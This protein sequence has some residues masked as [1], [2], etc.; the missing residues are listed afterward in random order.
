MLTERELKIIK[1]LAKGMSNEEM[2]ELLHISVHTT[3]A[4]L[5]SIYEKLNVKNRVQAVVKS[6][7]NGIIDM[8]KITF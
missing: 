1:L 8:Q 7:Q 5:E 6:A 2:S 4:H 3:K